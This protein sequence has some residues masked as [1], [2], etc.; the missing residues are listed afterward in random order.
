MTER[1]KTRKL[2]CC[3]RKARGNSLLDTRRLDAFVKIVD[4]GSVTRAAAVLRIAQ[5]ALSQQI[6]GLEAEFKAQLLVRSTR[7]VTPTPAGLVLY[8]YARSI[9][10]Q[11]QEAQRTILDASRELAGSVALGLAPWSTASL[12]APALLR[13]VRSQHPGI[14]LHISDTFGIT[15]SELTL[16]GHMDIAVLY[17]DSPPRGLLYK[18]VGVEQFCL[19][20][21]RELVPAET[22]VG[23]DTIAHT[24][25]IL[26]TEESFL[27]QLVDRT[28]QGAGTS[29]QIVSEVYS[30]DILSAALA[31]GVGATV[32]PRS[33]AS[34]LRDAE[35]LVIV[36]IEPALSMPV[37]IC[38]PDSAGLSDA[39]FAVH[40]LV[41]TILAERFGAPD[42]AEPASAK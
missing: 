12:I 39:A 20:G 19:V 24:P 41:I 29:P 25:L 38:I 37:S 16:R 23:I 33:V 7:G 2:W 13:A 8:R 9:H 34:S 28:C 42:V 11:L 17:G 21:N 4:L 36:P 5:P 14:L 18:P 10:R 31:D 1:R 30:S 6:A 40:Q 22:T 27:R 32:L 35:Q 15:F 26:P 3:A